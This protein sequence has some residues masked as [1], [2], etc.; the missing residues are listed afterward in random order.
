LTGATLKRRAPSGYKVIN[1]FAI[2]R[3]QLCEINVEAVREL[4]PSH[5]ARGADVVT[6]RQTKMQRHLRPRD[7]RDEALYEG[8]ARRNIE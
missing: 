2:M 4:M 8:P 7:G 6:I 3:S 5:N 1:L